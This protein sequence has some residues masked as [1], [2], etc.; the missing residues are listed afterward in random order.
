MCVCVRVCKCAY[1]CV[2]VGT[3]VS[4]RVC[5]FVCLVFGTN[6]CVPHVIG[7]TYLYKYELRVVYHSDRAVESVM[8]SAGARACAWGSECVSCRD[9]VCWAYLCMYEG[10]VVYDA[11]MLETVLWRV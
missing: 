3:F 10:C 9:H 6:R 11:C 5:L 8:D 1:E 2:T 7:L 4:S